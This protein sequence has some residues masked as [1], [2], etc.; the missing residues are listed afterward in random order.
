M[1]SIKKFIGTDV[2]LE[3]S[4]FEYGVICK[5]YKKDG[6]KDEYFC[7]YNQNGFFAHVQ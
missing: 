1:K 4:L 5:P 7:V 3:I 2:N 6:R